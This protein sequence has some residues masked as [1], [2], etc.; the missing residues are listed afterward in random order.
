MEIQKKIFYTDLLK[1]CDIGLSTVIVKKNILP[2]NPFPILKTKED[3]VLWL[4][5]AKKK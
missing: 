1:S 2:K 3:Y 4:K 5:L